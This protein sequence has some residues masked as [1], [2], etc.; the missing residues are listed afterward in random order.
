M[1]SPFTGLIVHKLAAT[2]FLLL[3]LVHIVVCRKKLGVRRWALLGGV[4]LAFGSGILSL[5]F[6]ALPWVLAL[7]KAVSMVCVCCL[8]IHIFAYRRAL[9][10]D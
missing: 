2:A 1:Y 7:H 6:A 3:C 9:K 8:A 5:I 4:M 10:G